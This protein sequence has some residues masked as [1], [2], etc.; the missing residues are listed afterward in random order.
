[1]TTILD[2]I[3]DVKKVELERHQ[4][5]KPL[6]AL[7]R[8]IAELPPALNF[9]G[10][11]WGPGVRLIA[12]VKKAS[13]SRGLLLADFDPVALASTYAGNGA[14][15]ISVLTEVDHFQGSLEHLRR[16]S[17]AVHGQGVAEDFNVF[18]FVI[19][20][21]PVLAAS[22]AVTL[23][24]IDGNPAESQIRLDLIDLC[25]IAFLGTGL[26]MDGYLHAELEVSNRQSDRLPA[27]F[28][29]AA[30]LGLQPAYL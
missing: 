9:S 29:G 17:D 10:C 12:E 7:E 1:M 5:E 22:F 19:E 20:D 15:A 2:Q 21:R 25:A 23:G 16:V 8:R 4:R 30:A 11:I 14:A 18:L 6:A 24:H 13:P 3:L 26:D 28:S 27:A